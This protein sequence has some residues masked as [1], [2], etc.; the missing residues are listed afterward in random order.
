MSELQELDAW[1]GQG[2]TA[3]TVDVST[4]EDAGATCVQTFVPSACLQPLVRAELKSVFAL[5]ALRY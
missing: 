5:L 4:D 3:A 1:A 2:L